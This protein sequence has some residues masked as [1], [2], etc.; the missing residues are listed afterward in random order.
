M[1][2]KVSGKLQILPGIKNKPLG[3]TGFL[4]TTNAF[5]HYFISRKHNCLSVLETKN[6]DFARLKAK[7]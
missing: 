2:P 3:F 4:K 1:F 7:Q 6:C 5:I